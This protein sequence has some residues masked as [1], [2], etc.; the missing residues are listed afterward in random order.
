MSKSAK[1]VYRAF[2]VKNYKDDQG[3][4]WSRWSEIGV[5]FGHQD[6]KG[7]DLILEAFP[8]S[9]RIVIRADEPRADRGDRM[10][11]SEAAV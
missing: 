3:V 8:V 1:P 11:R 6:Q 4:E 10:G 9:G 7:F 5:L 2:S